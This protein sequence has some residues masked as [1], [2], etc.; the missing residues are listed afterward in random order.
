MLK[1]EQMSKLTII[2]PKSLSY[3]IVDRLHSMRIYHLMDHARTEDLDIGSPMGDSE[4][5]SELLV[6][7]RS[8]ISFLGIQH[9]NVSQNLSQE[10]KPGLASVKKKMEGLNDRISL[11][12]S[13]IKETEE[14][15]NT[16]RERRDITDKISLLKISLDAFHD[17]ESIDHLLGYIED[18]K[19]LSEELKSAKGR[20][21]TLTAHEGGKNIALFFFDKSL[22][23]E[24]S[25]KLSKRGF[26]EID[27]SFIR[28]EGLRGRASEEL[29][30]LDSRIKE[31]ERKKLSLKKELED[32]KREWSGY[33]LR[34]ESMLSKEAE[35][36]E[37]PL[38]FGAT[39]E[40]FVI[41]GFVPSKKLNKAMKEIE[42]VSNG[43]VYMYSEE[44]S[45]EDEVPIKLD[46]PKPVRFYEW[47]MDLYTLPK[48]KEIDPT[49]LMF[50]TFPI[51]YG[52]MLGDV[53]YG[54][55]TLILFLVLRTRI[56]G[57]FGR[58][59]NAMIFASISTIIFG[60][61][62][63]EYFGVELYH[64]ILINRLHDT[65]G[66]LLA[67]IAIGAAHVN[68]GLLVG[69]YNELR[70]HGLESAVFEKLS[71]LVLEA[72]VVLLAL[73]FTGIIPYTPHPAAGGLL[74]ALAVFMIYK[75]E[76]A[77]GLVEIPAIFSHMLSYARLMAVG[78]ASVTLAVVVNDL[79]GKLF[80]AG[81]AGAIGA[82][83]LL[84]AG[85][86]L[87][88]G[89]GLIS[90]FLHSLRLHYVEFFTKFYHG[91]GMR[92]APFGA[93]TKVE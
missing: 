28:D 82:V 72:G 47:F 48:Y 39:E 35:K 37:A 92:Y 60:A 44:I 23:Q 61:L 38:R 11:D 27:T 57:D 87:N 6:T 45:E 93:E 62:F 24:I 50:L 22:R 81:I 91:G 63:A 42:S 15:I 26:T 21:R 69:F 66:L 52:F 55:V 89:L 64:P 65:H 16:L 59:V 90:P 85:H 84:G 32:T 83:L 88:I 14:S 74:A 76:G 46:N 9:K 78:L 20:C 71:W 36:A 33:L 2:G 79:S 18:V 31:L 5:I 86:T 17:Y 70:S 68:I 3:N 10:E 29:K 49:F 13:R 77:K 75:G 51:F 80:A 34:T 30:K 1:P 25:E 12:S 19:G 73:S 4:E 8:L 7:L 43:K 67:A 41:K 58:L 40:A 56:K 54:A 53:G